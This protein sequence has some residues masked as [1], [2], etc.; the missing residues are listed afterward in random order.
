MRSLKNKGVTLIELVIVIALLGIIISLGFSFFSFGNKSFSRGESQSSIQNSVR[1]ASRYIT[2]EI[3]TSKDVMLLA[4][5]PDNFEAFNYIY[6][7]GTKIIHKKPD[8]STHEI[9]GSS[10]EGAIGLHLQPT[11]GDKVVEF[12]IS[13]I[14][15]NQNFKVKSSVSPL[16]LSVP[17]VIQKEH[18]DDNSWSTIRYSDP[19]EDPEAIVR[20]DTLL[21]D[22]KKLNDFLDTDGDT[23][24]LDV[25]TKR[26]NRI[27]LPLIGE[28][29]AD[30]IWDSNSSYLVTNGP[31]TGWVYRPLSNGLD[32][33]I[34]ITATISKNGV[35]KTKIFKFRVKKL[36]PLEFSTE[37]LTLTVQS[38]SYFSHQ[39]FAVGGNPGYTFTSVSLPEGVTLSSDGLISGELELPEEATDNYIISIPI[40]LMDTHYDINGTLNSNTIS[41]NLTI[42]VE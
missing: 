26:P 21:L 31:N 7:E 28:I 41:A 40:S 25:P 33:D 35:E 17:D 13:K 6:V 4:E 12:T 32:Q 9:F 1:I 38:G 37:T 34:D 36:D 29:G 14:I 27:N 22:L 2:D 8:G 20:L 11:V 24:V 15:N 3:R 5:K 42:I 39:L 10:E 16:N 19:I 23:L 18:T 30:I